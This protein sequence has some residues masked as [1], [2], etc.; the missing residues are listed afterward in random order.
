MD[1]AH[2]VAEDIP[3]AN[4]VKFDIMP[5]QSPPNEPA[6]WQ[7]SED[8]GDVV[9]TLDITDSV[10]ANAAPVSTAPE[11]QPTLAETYEATLNIFGRFKQNVLALEGIGC[12]PV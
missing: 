9:F 12:D 8:S 6:N 4:V 5:A 10:V 3:Q 11:A 1:Y 7:T 2:R